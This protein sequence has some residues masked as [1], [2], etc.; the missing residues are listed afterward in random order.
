MRPATFV[1]LT[2]GLALAFGAAGI[3]CSSSGSSPPPDGAVVEAG[4]VAM[5]DA[6]APDVQPYPFNQVCKPVDD[7]DVCRKCA[8]ERCCETRDAIFATD[9]GGELVSCNAVS[10][11]GEAC[12][13]ACFGRFPAQVKPYLDHLGCM[14]HRCINEC[15]GPVSACSA[16]LDTNCTL[17]GLACNVSAECFLLTSCSAACATGD[18]TCLK[19]CAARHPDAVQL[20]ANLDVCGKNRCPTECATGVP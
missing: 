16:C 13:S 2:A 8:I 12:Q 5:P 6:G 19:A 1:T 14:A 3:A 10:G 15:A 17:D 18:Q 9:A 7:A 4:P 20:Q 11:C